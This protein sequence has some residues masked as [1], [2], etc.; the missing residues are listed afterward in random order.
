MGNNQ[1]PRYQDFSNA[2]SEKNKFTQRRINEQDEDQIDDEF[3]DRASAD[4][5]QYQTESKPNEN[6]FIQEGFLSDINVEGDIADSQLT[7]KN[8]NNSDEILKEKISDI[9]TKNREIDARDIHVA[10]KRGTV[11]LSGT[12]Q[13]RD[14]KI[15]VEMAIQDVKGVEDIKNNLKLRRW[16]QK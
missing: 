1:P 12:T 2:Q 4:Y 14:E 9:L 10:V 7:A 11:L 8:S 5:S 3:I 16:D 13:T 6:E 15:K